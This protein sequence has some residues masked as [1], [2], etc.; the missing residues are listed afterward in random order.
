VLHHHPS[1]LDELTPFEA[2]DLRHPDGSL[3]RSRAYRVRVPARISNGDI[4]PA[5]PALKVTFI[6]VTELDVVSAKLH[7]GMNNFPNTLNHGFEL[8]TWLV[9][10]RPERLGLLAS[11]FSDILFSTWGSRYAA[12]RQPLLK[13]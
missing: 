5:T 3:K 2:V 13:F 9:R 1:T 11:K 6:A 8:L 4:C 12:G 10:R 7:L